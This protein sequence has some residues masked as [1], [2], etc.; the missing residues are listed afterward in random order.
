MD[1]ALARSSSPPPSLYV[2]PTFEIIT[3]LPCITELG[4]MRSFD[5]GSSPRSGQ[6]ACAVILPTT[7][8]LCT[9]HIRNHHV[10]PMY[11]RIGKDE[12]LRPRFESTQWTTRLRGHPPH[13]HPCIPPHRLNIFVVSSCTTEPN[14]CSLLCYRWKS[15]RTPTRRKPVPGGSQSRIH[16]L[17][18]RLTC[19]DSHLPQ[20]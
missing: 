7:I 14:S 8:S 5:Q 12:K 18:G 11:H 16:A 1:N 10:T 15:Y 19:N 4:R 20:A 6:R 13:H 17:N 2:P 9:S 3:S